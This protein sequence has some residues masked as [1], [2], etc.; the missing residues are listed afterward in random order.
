[1]TKLSYLIAEYRGEHDTRNDERICAIFK[2]HGGKEEGSGYEFGSMTRDI[3][4]FVPEERAVACVA[5]LVDAGFRVS[6]PRYKPK[7]N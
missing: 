4:Y 7:K 3:G 1:M 6:S 5:A 2:A